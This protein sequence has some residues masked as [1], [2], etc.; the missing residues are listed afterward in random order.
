M[1]IAS[2]S[3]VYPPRNWGSRASADVHCTSTWRLRSSR[4][5]YER[6][7]K[8][9]VNTLIMNGKV[10]RDYYMHHTVVFWPEVHERFTFANLAHRH[11][12]SLQSAGH[13]WSCSQSQGSTAWTTAWC[14]HIVASCYRWKKRMKVKMMHAFKSEVWLLWIKYRSARWLTFYDVCTPDDSRSAYCWL[15]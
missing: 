12:P 14:R 15:A 3:S 9:N 8:F 13:V 11:L 2:L 4:A 7:V 6:L 1:Q 5:F 10:L